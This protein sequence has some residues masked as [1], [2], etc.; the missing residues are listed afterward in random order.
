MH[1]LAI[2]IVLVFTLSLAA[3]LPALAAPILAGTDG[4]TAYGSLASAGEGLL[5]GLGVDCPVNEQLVLGGGLYPQ[6]GLDVIAFN[7]TYAASE[8]LVIHADGVLIVKGFGVQSQ[9]GAYY[10]LAEPLPIYLGG[11]VWFTSVGDGAAALYAEAEAHYKP[12]KEWMLYAGLTLV[13]DVEI[14]VGATYSF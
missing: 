1:K 8:T 6:A 5:L 14:Q 9:L 12:A 2:T 11:G 10:V 3:A 13:S 7:G 4:L